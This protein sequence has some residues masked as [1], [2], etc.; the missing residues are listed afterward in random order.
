KLHA[1]VR[2]DIVLFRHDGGGQIFSVGSIR[3]TNGLL[4][5]HDKMQVASVTE[6]ALRDLLADAALRRGAVSTERWA[7]C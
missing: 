6:A 7:A 2:G 5:P 1:M 4:D 3:W